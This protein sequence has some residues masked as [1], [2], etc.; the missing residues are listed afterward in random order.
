MAATARTNQ[1]TG[2]DR[3]VSDPKV[4]GGKPTVRDTSV[5]VERILAQLTANPDIDAVLVRHP[6]LTSE[7]IKAVMEYARAAVEAVTD[8]STVQD[9]WANYDP[10]KV[11]PAFEALR[12]ALRGVDLDELYADIREARGHPREKLPR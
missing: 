12:E 3:I 5:P 10:E 8:R 7:D 2:G 6:N 4:H 9:I 11:L 1:P